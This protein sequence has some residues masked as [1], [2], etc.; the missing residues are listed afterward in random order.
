M[1]DCGVYES[2]ILESID[3]PLDAAGRE[4]LR[5]H[6]AACAGCR[7]FQAIQTG[8]ES[9]LAREITEPAAPRNLERRLRDEIARDRWRARLEALFTILEPV[10]ALAVVVVLGHW[11]TAAAAAA[12]ARFFHGG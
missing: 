2:L 3:G 10:A 12:S 6:L 7:R 8:L 9:L 5:V 4:R 11:V 1:A